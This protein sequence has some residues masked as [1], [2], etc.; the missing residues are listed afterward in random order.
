MLA[1]T[2]DNAASRNLT[3]EREN[4]GPLL[5]PVPAAIRDVGAYP[6]VFDT[7]HWLSAMAFEGR[8]YRM[9]N[10]IDEF[11]RECLAI[12]VARKLKAVDVIDLLSDCQ[13]ALNI[14]P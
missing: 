12:R 1:P 14:D 5:A 8:K 10:V 4:R 13:S 11:T 9:L 6:T 3:S 2:S 7:G